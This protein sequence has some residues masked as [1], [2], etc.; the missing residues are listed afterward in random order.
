M[1]LGRIFWLLLNWMALVGIHNLWRSM[2]AER[3][4]QYTKCAAGQASRVI[5]TFV[6][7][8]AN[9]RTNNDGKA[10]GP[11]AIGM[12]VASNAQIWLSRLMARPRNR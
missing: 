10:N 3:L 4:L 11:L 2:G 6:Q 12:Q 5:V 8:P 7:S 1:Q 9:G